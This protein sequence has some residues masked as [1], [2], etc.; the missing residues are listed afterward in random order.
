MRGKV[1]ILAGTAEARAVC[2]AVSDRNVVAS[3]AGNTRRP[4]DLGVPMRAGGFGGADGFRAALAQCA[5]VL[6][7]T[8]PFAAHMSERTARLCRQAGVPH[9]R[10]TRPAWQGRPGWIHHGTA[11]SVAVALPYDA[12]V[13]LAVGPG[14]VAP[15]LSGGARL[16]CRRIDPAANLPGLSWIVGR[17]QN[18]P[19]TEAALF[20][21]LRITHLV[22]KNSGGH[23]AK[24][25]AADQLG[26]IVHMIDRPPAV[27]GRETHDIAKAIA[28]VREHAAPGPDHSR[29]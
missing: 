13:F 14:S 4:V 27:E 10:L 22:T 12:R 2:A 3:L 19:E 26:L 17:P 25:D 23:D 1:L 16:W 29:G 20:R 18:T 15:F 9:L 11:D 6:D 24:L 8:H 21:D 28:F 7:A 5:A